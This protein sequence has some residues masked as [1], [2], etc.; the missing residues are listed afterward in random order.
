MLVEAYE[1]DRGCGVWGLSEG[2]RRTEGST[3]L[4]RRPAGRCRRGRGGRGARSHLQTTNIRVR[5][6]PSKVDESE[7]TKLI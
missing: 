6:S 1:R 4:L 7:G 3:L 2:G 5:H